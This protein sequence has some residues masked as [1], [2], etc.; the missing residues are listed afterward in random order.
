MSRDTIEL[1][2]GMSDYYLRTS[3][4]STNDQGIFLKFPGMEDELIGIVKNTNNLDLNSNNF[5]FT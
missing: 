3:P 4:F 5:V 1:H 2:G